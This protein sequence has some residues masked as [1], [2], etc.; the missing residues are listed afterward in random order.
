MQPIY[1]T[2]EQSTS[3]PLP[4]P[5]P[6][7][8]SDTESTNHSHHYNKITNV[9]RQFLETLNTKLG[10]FK[11]E[12]HI[13]PR[14]AKRRSVSLSSRDDEWNSDSA[15]SSRPASHT[16]SIQQ[17]L[18]SFMTGNH[19]RSSSTSSNSSSRHRRQS[20]EAVRKK[21]AFTLASCDRESLMASLNH[22]LA[23]RQQN[24]IAKAAAANA[25]QRKQ[26]VPDVNCSHYQNLFQSHQSLT[27]S[28][29]NLANNPQSAVQY[30]SIGQ[31]VSQQPPQQQQIYGPVLHQQQ[32]QRRSSQPTMGIKI[33]NSTSRQPT[34]DSVSDRQ[35]MRPMMTNRASG[36]TTDR[37]SSQQSMV[38]S[39]SNDYYNRQTRNPMP[40]SDS[41]NTSVYNSL[42]TN[43]T[44][45]L[46]TRLPPNPESFEN[47]IAARVN[48]WF[49]SVQLPH[50]VKLCRES[51]MDQIRRGKPL[52]KVAAANDRSAPKLA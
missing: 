12:S 47:A 16:Q 6:E 10:Q 34:Y 8:F 19:S 21:A 45:K 13:S 37:Q 22:R 30:Q 43:E 31:P 7:A 18:M 40:S 26:S 4:A 49:N 51:L 41:N 11:P 1:T 5:P 9:H 44:S 14:L 48:S 20:P 28:A 24:E 36:D 25:M 33:M 23:Q 3:L 35:T 46:A 52:R 50:D 2:E 29:L 15:V 32:L 39:F 42:Q 38:Q 17:T 27:S